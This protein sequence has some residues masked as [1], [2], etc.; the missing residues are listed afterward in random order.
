MIERLWRERL[1]DRRLKAYA[2][3]EQKEAARN[4]FNTF[5]DL[6][7]NGW[8]AE[9]VATLPTWVLE[10]SKHA[11]PKLDRASQERIDEELARR[12]LSR[13]QAEARWSLI[14]AALSMLISLGSWLAK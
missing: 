1:L 9:M 7:T 14:V 6:I 11:D 10:T 4:D 8:T 5:F 2:K 12:R 13:S 3:W